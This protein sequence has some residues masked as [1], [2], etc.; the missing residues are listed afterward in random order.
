MPQ[1][2]EIENIGAKGLNTDLAAWSLPPEFLTFGVNFRVF[3]NQLQTA[4]GWENWST[5]PVDFDAAHV[6]HVGATSG[7]YWLVA[8]RSAVYAFDGTTWTDISSLA[9]YAA[10]GPDQELN[11]T[12]CLMGQFPIINNPQVYPEYWGG[13]SLEPPSPA[14]AMQPL[15]WDFGVGNTWDDVNQ[16]ARIIRSHKTFMFALDLINNGVDERDAYRW[17]HPADINGLPPQWDDTDPLYLAGKANIGSRTGRIVDGQS[18]RDSFVIYSEGGVSILDFDPNSAFVW[19]RRELSSALGLLSKDALIEVKGRHYFLSDGDIAANDGNQVGSIMH[20]R[21]RRMLSSRIST[22]YYQRAFA[23]RNFPFSEIWFCVPID[24]AEFPNLALIYNYQDDTWATRDMPDPPVEL[25][26]AGY[27]SQ[28]VPTTSWDT[29]AG[30]WDQQTRVWGSV[31]RTPLDDTIVGV[32]RAT[33]ELIF[34]DPKDTR[35]VELGTRVER[36]GY[37]LGGHDDVTTITRVYPHIEGTQPLTIQ[38]GSHDKAGGA[39]RWKPAVL[40]T[41]GV[42]RKID[43]RTTGELHA[44]RFQSE[45]FGNWNLS[46]FTVE[47]EAGAKR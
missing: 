36:I 12:S 42:D 30:T 33:S 13:P 4:G 37:P 16:Q 10:I 14:F 11:W 2:L 32:N 17:S 18:L 46:G 15:P 5:A 44:W 41:P 47:Y 43:I 8:G 20:N 35:E 28:V 31:V 6:I 1:V 9:G 25:A 22:D 26:F 7:E 27:G 19:R 23:V 24:G 3:A 38:F 40:F 45:G 39:I 29:W 21:V 34:L